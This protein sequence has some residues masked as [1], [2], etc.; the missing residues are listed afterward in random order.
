MKVLYSLSQDKS[1][2]SSYILGLG[3]NR[4]TRDNRDIFN[5]NRIVSDFDIVIIVIS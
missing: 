1:K 4:D 3:N 2:Y 5:D